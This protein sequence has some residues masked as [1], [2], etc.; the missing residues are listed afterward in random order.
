MNNF[1]KKIKDNW[2]LFFIMIQPIIDVIAYFQTKTIEKSYSWI[3]RIIL[4]VIMAFFVFKNSKN[5]K[6]LLIELFP[7]AIFFVLHIKFI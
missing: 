5:K 4:L 6:K 1:F 7:F 3:I 2:L